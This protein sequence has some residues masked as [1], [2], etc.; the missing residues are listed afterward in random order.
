[1]NEKSIGSENTFEGG[2]QEIRS[3]GDVLT[4]RQRKRFKVGDSLLGRYRILS[5][6]GQGGHGLVFRCMTRVGA[7]RS[8]SSFS[9]RKWRTMRARWRGA[10]EFRG[11]VE[12]LHHPNIAALKTL[13]KDE[14]TGEYLLVME[15]V[16]GV[17]LRQYLRSQGQLSPYGGYM[18]D[19]AHAVAMGKQIA[20]ALDYAHSQKIMHRD[21]KPSNIMVQADGTVKILDFGLASQ[22]HTSMSRVKSHGLRTS[23]PVPTWL[24]SM[25][26]GKYQDASTDHM[27]WRRGSMRCWRVALPST[28]MSRRAE[29]IG[30][31]RQAGSVRNCPL[32]VVGTSKS[33]GQGP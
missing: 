8:P 32:A 6:L 5:E 7:S 21:I 16:D 15:C 3:I 14:A 27:H 12:K 33:F 10:R 2:L 11:I 25:W 29:R 20:S 1:M 19:F 30:P 9:P 4:Q 26:K 31:E 23:G 22:I 18:I 13:E 24:P 28:A 17:N